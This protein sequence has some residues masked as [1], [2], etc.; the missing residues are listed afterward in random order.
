[1]VSTQSSLEKV[2]IPKVVPQGTRE[3]VPGTA[4]WLNGGYRPSFLQVTA[5]VGLFAVVPLQVTKNA[6]VSE[7]VVV[8]I[9]VRTNVESMLAHEV[10]STAQVAMTAGP[11]DWAV[12]TFEFWKQ[13]AP[14]RKQVASAEAIFI[15]FTKQTI[16]PTDLK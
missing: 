10:S 3:T 2:F 7:I 6:L 14:T 15:F 9:E 16:R 12:A 5:F 4:S 11:A 13:S 8:A 1:M